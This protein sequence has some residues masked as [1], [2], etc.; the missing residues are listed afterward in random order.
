[1]CA[2]LETLIAVLTSMF[3]RI[4]IDSI[5]INFQMIEQKKMPPSPM[6]SNDFALHY[7]IDKPHLVVVFTYWTS[8]RE[9]WEAE[10]DNIREMSKSIGVD[11]PIV[12]KDAT[13]QQ[14]KAV[15]TVIA[16]SLNADKNCSLILF[17]IGHG[18]TWR[19]SGIQF[20]ENEAGEI[21]PIDIFFDIFSNEK[22]PKFVGKPRLI[23][24]QSCRGGEANDGSQFKTDCCTNQIGYSYPSIS[25]F[26]LLMSS[27]ESVK[28]L[29]HKRG[30]GIFIQ[31]LCKAITEYKNKPLEEIV[32]YVNR[33]MQGLNHGLTQF[34][35]ISAIAHGT[36]T[37]TFTFAD[38]NEY[39]LF[40]NLCKMFTSINWKSMMYYIFKYLSSYLVLPY[41]QAF[42]AWLLLIILIA[43]LDSENVMRFVMFFLFLYLYLK[44]FYLSFPQFPKIAPI[45]I[46]FVLLMIPVLAI[47]IISAM[48]KKKLITNCNI[49]Y[50]F[51]T[52]FFYKKLYFL[53]HNS[54]LSPIIFRNR[55]NK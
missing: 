26:F 46:S 36:L 44:C 20:L 30:G 39:P 25:D 13:L 37:K 41:V 6:P 16:N 29:R 51:H 50:F 45:I 53:F 34:N 17:L 38:S 1:M 3:E 55:K 18:G 54:V 19:N 15:L 40:H 31:I 49:F 9:G 47:L 52:I 48:S 23:F 32:K 21:I 4:E 43:V 8:E 2:S 42:F 7:D 11:E 28:S 5:K 12:Y 35:P 14:T 33:Q 24:V 22:I 27:V 10:I